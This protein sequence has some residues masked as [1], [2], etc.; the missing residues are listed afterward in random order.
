MPPPQKNLD[1]ATELAFESLGNQSEHQMQWLGAELQSGVW[2]VPVLDETIEVDL[3]AQ[4][5]VTSAGAD[6]G[7]HWRIIILH[8]LAID[9]QPEQQPPEVVFA[10][11]ENAR[12]YAGV[13]QGR[14]IYRFCGTAGR[15]GEK[16]REAAAS[17]GGRAVEEGDAAFDFDLFPRVAMRLIWYAPDEEFPPSATL[18]LPANLEAYFCSEDIVVLSEQLISRL[19]GRGF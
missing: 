1:R 6:V 5:V 9:V 3:A 17:L 4:R 19:C 14:V 11:L 2:R 15:D 16:F 7:P 10:D 12:S 13:Y 8:Y 18:L